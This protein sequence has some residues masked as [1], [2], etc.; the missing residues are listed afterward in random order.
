MLIRPI[1]LA[2][3]LRLNVIVGNIIIKVGSSIVLGIFFPFS[4]SILRLGFPVLLR[5]AFLVLSF[6]IRLVEF[7]VICLQTRIFYGL[8]V[9]YLAE[10]IIKPE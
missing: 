9:S 7:C 8:V 6:F 3:R 10:V 2:A 1:T 5:I 4:Y